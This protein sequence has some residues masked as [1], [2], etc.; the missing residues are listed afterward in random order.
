MADLWQECICDSSLP[1]TEADFHILRTMLEDAYD[2]QGFELNLE[3][4]RL[5]MFAAEM[6]SVE[7]LPQSFMIYLGEM[8][9]KADR[10]FWGFSYANRSSILIVGESGG[11]RFRI[12]PD[13]STV[14]ARERWSVEGSES[15][16][17]ELPGYKPP[18][19]NG[20]WSLVATLPKDPPDGDGQAV[21]IFECIIPTPF[22][23]IRAIE[24]RDSVGGT[25]PALVLETGSGNNCEELAC[26]MARALTRG[27][28]GIG[29]A[30]NLIFS[31]RAPLSAPGSIENN[32]G[33]GGDG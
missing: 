23:R 9:E 25:V 11:G 28:L 15:H 13:G 12:Y 30:E 10:S 21:E 31:R 24:S 4:G 20:R 22:Y 17:D 26:A 19:G 29:E 18:D 8:I 3:A 5:V 27:L 33:D 7:E 32:A 1:C 14:F 16:V 6:G 2:V